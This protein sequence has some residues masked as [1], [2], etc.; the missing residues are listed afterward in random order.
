MCTLVSFRQAGSCVCANVCDLLILYC[1]CRHV[2]QSAFKRQTLSASVTGRRGRQTGREGSGAPC[3]KQQSA[4]STTKA[5]SRLLHLW[6]KV[7]SQGEKENTRSFDKFY[8][9]QIFVAHSFCFDLKSTF[10]W[11]VNTGSNISF[12]CLG[13]GHIVVV[14]YRNHTSSLRFDMYVSVN[15]CLKAMAEC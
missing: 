2:G 3:R 11:T 1:F 12:S 13:Y 10:I 7:T 8:F 6:R 4:G 9:S 14:I 5:S 15:V